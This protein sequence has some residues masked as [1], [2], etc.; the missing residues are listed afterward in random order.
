[1]TSLLRTSLLKSPVP[2]LCSQLSTSLPPFSPLPPPSS[3]RQPR[4][5]HY[6]I[7]THGQLFLSSTPHKNFTSSYKD[8]QFLS[9]FFKRLRQL[10][11]TS[12][13]PSS[14]SSFQ[15]DSFTS[16]EV[17]DDYHWI[18]ECK[19]ERNYLRSEC[20]NTPLVF[21]AIL[22]S[23]PPP[24][25]SFDLVLAGGTI[26]IPFDPS[27]L[28]IS[29]EGHVL[30]AL[31]PESSFAKRVGPWGLVGGRVVTE[32]LGGRI[33]EGLEREEGLFW[34]EANSYELGEVE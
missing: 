15:V 20:R 11:P 32:G 1:M 28:A 7:D 21:T 31:P 12:S 30:H 18:S 22:P 34:W 24:F 5:Y 19:S 26:R 4:S 13:S 8:P 6:T 17:E 23:S 27:S 33:R 29:S 14:S 10:A 3:S 2:T 25:S 9:I 16:N